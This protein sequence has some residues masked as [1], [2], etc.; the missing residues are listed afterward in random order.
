MSP[1]PKLLAGAA[2]LAFGAV[3]CGGGG[4]TKTPPADTGSNVVNATDAL[5]FSP[6]SITVGAGNAVEFRNTGSILHSVTLK[7]GTFD[8]DLKA[9]GTVTFTAPPAGT[10][11]YTCK[12]HAGMAGSI[13]VK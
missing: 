9:D 8:K 4:D 5:K 12:Y 7:D 6:A 3:A 2:L 13:T 11:Q 10:V 1:N